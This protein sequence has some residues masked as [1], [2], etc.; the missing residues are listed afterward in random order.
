MIDIELPTISNKVLF[1][2]SLF[3]TKNIFTIFITFFMVNGLGDKDNEVKPFGLILFEWFEFVLMTKWF[4]LLSSLM[5]ILQYFI[6]TKIPSIELMFLSTCIV[7]FYVA[8][9]ASVTFSKEIIKMS[10]D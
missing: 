1:V 3:I 5:L 4:Y 7:L 8:G 2:F 6:L 10:L 9:L